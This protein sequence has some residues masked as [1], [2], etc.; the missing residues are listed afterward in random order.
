M[1]IRQFMSLAVVSLTALVALAMVAGRALPRGEQFLFSTS[2]S[3]SSGP[4]SISLVDVARRLELRIVDRPHDTRP[5]F[6]V[7]WSPD[8]SHIVYATQIDENTVETWMVEIGA[9]SSARRLNDGVSQVEYGAVWSPAG[10]LLAF[11]GQPGDLRQV[12]LTDV[13]GSFTRQLTESSP[14]FKSAIWSPDGTRLALETDSADEDLAILPVEQIAAPLVIQQAGR[15]IRPVWSPDGNWIA[16]LSNRS[17]LERD[18]VYFDLF[19]MRPDGTDVQQLTTDHPALSNWQPSWSADG[20]WLSVAAWSWQGGDRIA[21]VDIEAGTVV[22]IMEAGAVYSSPV[23]SPTGATLAF[24]RRAER[25]WGIW[26][27]DLAA[28]SRTPL[29]EGIVDARRPMW[30]PDGERLLYR[31]NR[32]GNWDIFMLSLADPGAVE[33]LT[34]GHRREYAPAWRP[35]A[36]V[37]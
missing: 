17:T 19:I 36:L 15:D 34:T 3:W 5:G 28:G 33:R 26:L 16:F 12:Y 13:G 25:S 2:R 23:W 18:P 37:C 20:R 4:W 22:P 1:M 32:Y 7:V 8:G 35:C 21:L 10:E 27:Y 11:I 14:G 31:S 24:E 6:P 30:I 9:V 29:V